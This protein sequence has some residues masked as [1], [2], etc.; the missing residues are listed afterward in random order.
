LSISAA[1]F[2]SF[3]FVGAEFILLKIKTREEFLFFSILNIEYPPAIALYA[4]KCK[5]VILY[6]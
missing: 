1:V 6:M 2:T 3:S 5:I 4:D